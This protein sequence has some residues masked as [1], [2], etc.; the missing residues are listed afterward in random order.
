VNV[1]NALNHGPV[2]R[3]HVKVIGSGNEEFVTGQTD[4]RGV[5]VADGIAGVP[6]TIVRD[7]MNLYAFYR[8]TQPF[9]V[10]PAPADKK[11]AEVMDQLGGSQPTANYLF[12]IV[13]ENTA[14]QRDNESRIQELFKQTQQGVQVQKAH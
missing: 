3:V 2:K 6:T 11:K 4:L 13:G 12:N 7:S 14:I 1:L 8:G 9:G 5:F 10:A